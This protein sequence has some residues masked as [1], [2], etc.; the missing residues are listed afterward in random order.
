MLLR[1][2]G[3]NSGA[4]M[5]TSTGIAAAFAAAA[6]AAAAGAAE[7][8]NAIVA[9]VNDAPI[10]RVEIDR[11]AQR[12][13]QG[14]APAGQE[15][16]QRVLDALI[17]R[18]LQLQRAQLYGVEISDEALDER[19]A[20]MARELE[21]PDGGAALEAAVRQ[22]FG[23]SPAQL[24]QRLREDMQIQALFYREIYARTDIRE[25][26]VLQFLK[27]EAGVASP[28]EYR[29][30][31]ILIAVAAD[32]GAAAQAQ[33]QAQALSLQAR[34]QEGADFAALARRYSGGEAA[35]RG[36]DL[37]FMAE[38]ELPRAFV[39]ELQNM[40]AGEVSAPIATSRG[41]HLL[42]LLAA[43][44]GEL[45]ESARRF[46]L[47]HIFLPPESGA[48]AQEIWRTLGSDRDAFARAVSRYSV[49]EV[50]A[51]KQ[52]DIGWFEEPDLPGYFA[53]AVRQMEVGDISAPLQSPFG[54]HILRLSD[55][56]EEFF[57]LQRLRQ[58]ARQLLRERRALAKRDSWLR[59]LRAE[60]HVRLLDPAFV[61]T[62]Q[63]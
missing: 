33:A 41:V 19:L 31:H 10:T 1:R 53:P 13:R 2:A 12:L 6:F 14:G 5:N 60:A 40:E 61:D 54:W 25:D 20:E 48:Q 17:D 22:R 3:Y 16:R 43:R 18:Q 30:Q 8:L 47:G 32:A 45:R 4:G 9:V 58:Q 50:S 21:L 39:A 37:G 34:L 28:R 26:E 35:S 36:G 38:Q 49:D 15:L 27:A 42:K 55:A 11:E 57:D 63:R 7:P 51:A 52:G 59:R 44:G 29:L 46:R 23:V 24:R 56:E 62:R